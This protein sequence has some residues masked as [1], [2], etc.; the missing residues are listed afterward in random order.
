MDMIPCVSWSC[1]QYCMIAQLILKVNQCFGLEEK[2]RQISRNQRNTL[3]PNDVDSDDID[4]ARHATDMTP[5]SR[6]DRLH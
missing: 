3:R 2:A 4:A 1:M 6:H 5:G